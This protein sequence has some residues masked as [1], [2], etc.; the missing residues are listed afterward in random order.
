VTIKYNS[1][2]QQQWVVRYNGPGNSDDYASAL[3]LDGSGNVYVTGNSWGV[4]SYR[5]YATVKYN[6][7]GQEQWVARYDGPGSY[8]DGAHAI[9]VDGSGNVYVTGG[10]FGSNSDNDYATVK[11]NSAGQEQWVARHTSEGY[12]S[13]LGN[14]IAV[15]SSGNVYVTGKIA[16]PNQGQNSD[17]AT[18]KYVQGPT[19]SPTPRPTDFDFNNDGKADFVLYNPGT[20]QTAIWYM[21]NNVPIGGAMV[22]LF[23]RAG[24]W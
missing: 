17:Y 14:A 2:G 5:D 24:A 20:R 15:D 1:A 11:Y 4:V 19:P 7:T 22:Q 18:V 21:N 9:A 10:S 3:A 6:S 13:D 12:N 8:D 23:P 16:V